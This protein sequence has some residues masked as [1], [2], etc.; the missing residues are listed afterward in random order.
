MKIVRH[1]FESL[2]STNVWANEHANTFET[3]ILTLVTA[4]QQTGGK[5]RLGRGWVS[6]EGKNIYATF[7]FFMD[8]QRKDIGNLPQVMAISAAEVLHQNDFSIKLK[9]PND[10]L[11]QSKKVGGI[12]TETKSIEDSLFIAIGVGININMLPDDVKAIDRPATS[13]Y[14]ESGKTF[15]V[16]EVIQ[17]LSK[18]FV[19]KLQQF[20]KEGFTPFISSYKERLAH[21]PH[22]EMS[23]RDSQSIWHGHFAGINSDGSLAMRLANGTLKTFVEGE[24]L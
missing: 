11:L 1:H 23:F 16:E 22:S 5:G 21:S 18:N 2:N 19:N 4:G 20:L 9:W 14:I 3:N 7:C 13:L 17:E 15:I 12:L 10:L 6:P 24:L 8:T